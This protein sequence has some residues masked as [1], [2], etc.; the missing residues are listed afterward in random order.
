MHLLAVS[1]FA[2]LAAQVAGH[3]AVTEY[4]IAGKTYPGYLQTSFLRE[5]LLL[6]SNHLL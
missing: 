1:T 2:I 6:F 3:G 4:V 5:N